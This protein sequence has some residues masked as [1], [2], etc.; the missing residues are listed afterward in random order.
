MKNNKKPWI[1]SKSHWD[2]H[3]EIVLAC[4]SP[5]WTSVPRS[6]CLPM[7]T[8]HL[9]AQ[10][11]IPEPTVTSVPRS[12]CSVPC[13]ASEGCRQFV[14]SR[15]PV[16]SL[17]LSPVWKP[18]STGYANLGCT[19]SKSSRLMKYLPNPS[20]KQASAHHLQ[21]WIFAELSWELH[22]KQDLALNWGQ[23]VPA[24]KCCG[25]SKLFFSL[26]RAGNYMCR[27]HLM[28]W[29][30]DW[31]PGP[32]SSSLRSGLWKLSH[33][34]TS[35]LRGKDASRGELQESE[36]FQQPFLSLV[37]CISEAM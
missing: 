30:P 32:E 12:R 37:M 29:S 3:E 25:T 28:T 2:V 27:G 11:Q 6:R 20:F 17:S 23:Q 4:L 22:Y 26:I 8:G 36:L 14:T 15:S 35:W 19:S 5:Q 7:P 34:I 16:G 1:V 9:C 18:L 10:K 33:A 21:T 13:H 31:V 24:V